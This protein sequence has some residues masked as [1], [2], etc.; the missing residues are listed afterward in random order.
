M[1]FKSI[2]FDIENLSIEKIIELLLNDGQLIKRSFLKINESKLI[3]WF[4][5]NEYADQ[6]K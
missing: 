1:N 6:F 2:Y 4:N 5:E 3:L